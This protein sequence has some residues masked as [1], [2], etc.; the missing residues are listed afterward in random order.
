M[1][2]KA[3]GNKR[4]WE[5]MRDPHHINKINPGKGSDN[6]VTWEWLLSK[7]GSEQLRPQQQEGR[8]VKARG[9]VHKSKSPV[10]GRIQTRAGRPVWPKPSGP[11]RRKLCT[12]WG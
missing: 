12:D 8:R 4:W 11:G 6:R 2:D 5:E 7:G 10:I 3:L 9:R 1:T